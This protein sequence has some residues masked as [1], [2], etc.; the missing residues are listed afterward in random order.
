MTCAECKCNLDAG[1]FNGPEGEIF[2]KHCYAVLFGHKAKS[3][4]KGWN[5]PKTIM[6]NEGD[7]D[8][9]P[10]CEGK[11]FEA[12]KCP[13]KVGG[14]HKNCFSCVECNRKLDS[15]TCCEGPDREI[16]CKSCYAVFF[17]SKSRSRPRAAKLMSN[18]TKNL[19]KFYDNED[20][21]L[22]RARIETWVIKAEKDNPDCCPKCG[23]RVFEAE[24]MVTASG[25]WYHKNCF[26]CF[27][28]STMLDSLKNNDGPDGNIY[29]KMCYTKKYGP[30]NRPTDIDLKA[31]NT[32][33]IKS[34]DEKKNCPR[35]GGA[36]FNN[37]EVASK[38][39]SYHKKC[40]TCLACEKQLTFN[41]LYDGDDG[42]I[43]CKFCYYRKFAPVGYR[44]AGAVSWVDADTGNAL[45]HTYQAF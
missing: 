38:G 6:G 29:C 34:S 20:D 12:E 22:A 10:R 17:G 33:V 41:T 1:F 27:E 18:R 45:R 44:G 9:C 2:C 39:K 40:A 5:D 42:E 8:A 21:M 37:E 30:Q 7:A 36:V 11:V 35:C 28:C 26:K 24:K 16:Y 3:E 13:T 15:M 32:S 14:F 23:G 19:G 31:R 4:Y 25:K 43:Y